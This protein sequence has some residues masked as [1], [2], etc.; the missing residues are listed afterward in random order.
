MGLE[1]FASC[2]R[3]PCMGAAEASWKVSLREVEI[4]PVQSPWRLDP[5]GLPVPPRRCAS[6]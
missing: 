5:G 1:L 6:L 3:V 2:T 4:H